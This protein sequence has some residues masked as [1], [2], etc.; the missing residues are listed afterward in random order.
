MTRRLTLLLTILLIACA[1]AWAADSP[2]VGTW[3][4]TS[5]DDAGQT[6]TWTMVVKDDGGKL[7]GTLSGDPGEFALVDPKLD[8]NT[9]SFKV[10]VNEVSYG[11]EV[12]IDGTKLEGK[13][14]GPEANGT[15]KGTKQ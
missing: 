13:Y 11:V 10:V 12:T 6:S 7:A 14:K 9:F 3:N 2:V 5:T 4:C 8:G 1:A 15:L